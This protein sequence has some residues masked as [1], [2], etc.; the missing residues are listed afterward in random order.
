M[1]FSAISEIKK[2]RG[3]EYTESDVGFAVLVHRGAQESRRHKK[4]EA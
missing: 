4:S 1:P 3:E 2:I